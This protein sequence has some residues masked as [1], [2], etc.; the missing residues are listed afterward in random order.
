MEE[1]GEK[2]LYLRPL[3]GEGGDDPRYKVVWTPRGNLGKV[4]VTNV[5]IGFMDSLEPAVWEV[6]GTR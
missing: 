3:D 6:K 1:A 4:K 2:G 5:T